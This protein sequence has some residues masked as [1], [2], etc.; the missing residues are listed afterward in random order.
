LLS[1]ESEIRAGRVAQVV[2]C[3]LSKWV[4]IPVPPEKKEKKVN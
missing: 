1:L 3:M 2:E 4:Q